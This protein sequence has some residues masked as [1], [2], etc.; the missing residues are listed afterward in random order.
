MGEQK[1]NKRFTNAQGYL[2]M[3]MMKMV[4][5]YGISLLLL[6]VSQGCGDS[7]IAISDESQTI[8]VSVSENQDIPNASGGAN[9]L[10]PQTFQLVSVRPL[11]DPNLEEYSTDNRGVIDFI[12]SSLNGE[13]IPTD[14]REYFSYR[15]YQIIL[16]NG[17]ESDNGEY[18]CVLYVDPRNYQAYKGLDGG[19]YEADIQLARFI[20]N[21]CVLE[22]TFSYFADLSDFDLLYYG[23]LSDGAVS[24]GI[25]DELAERFEADPIK[26]GDEIYNFA[27]APQNLLCSGLVSEYNLSGREYE[28]DEI[29]KSYKYLNHPVLYKLSELAA[30]TSPA[31]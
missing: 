18:S 26:I 12:E 29:L 2:S 5:T 4:Y 25:Y 11:D 15:Q 9:E 10:L 7:D 23:T 13:F 22:T 20:H 28:L 30:P 31:S 6:T 17:Q 1:I 8:P 16:S 3:K 24:E 27:E 14:N 21:S 19:I